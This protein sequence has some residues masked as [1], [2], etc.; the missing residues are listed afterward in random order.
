[1]RREIEE[2]FKP[3]DEVQMEDAEG[4]RDADMRGLKKD[5][6][7]DARGQAGNDGE[8][9]VDD[10]SPEAKKASLKLSPMASW[11]I[12]NRVGH[13]ILLLGE[14]FLRRAAANGPILGKGGEAFENL[15]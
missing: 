6:E 15:R 14:G 3:S 10:R 8:E 1:M 5:F 4:N 12:R 2:D 7:E 11:R 9:R 13:E